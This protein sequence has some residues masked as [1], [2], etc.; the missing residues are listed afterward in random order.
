MHKSTM[1]PTLAILS[2]LILIATMIFG[3]NL[4]DGYLSGIVFACIA[5]STLAVGSALIYRTESITKASLAIG[6][7]VV[8]LSVIVIHVL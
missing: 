4:E 8:Q 6:L 2:L 1:G 5:L 7:S 3:Q